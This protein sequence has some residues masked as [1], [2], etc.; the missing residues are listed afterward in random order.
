LVPKLDLAALHTI[1]AILSH[2]NG[3]TRFVLNV[4]RNIEGG[5]CGGINR[6]TI[7]ITGGW[8]TTSIGLFNTSWH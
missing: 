6:N 5:G 1:N 3:Y 4:D 7:L 2:Y 8:I